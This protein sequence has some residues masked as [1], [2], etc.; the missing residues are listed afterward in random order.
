MTRNSIIIIAALVGGT[1]GS[2]A[3]AGPD[4]HAKMTGPNGSDMGRVEI[5]QGPR[6][7]LFR[8]EA[9]GLAESWHG[10]HVH[11]TGSC[12]EGLDAADGHYAPD[13][14]AHGLLNEAG[15]HAGD[16]PNIYVDATG[17]AR[18]EL[19]SE[20]LSVDGDVAPLLDDDGS[21]IMIHAQADSYNADAGA[22]DRVSC[23]VVERAG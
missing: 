4:A 11:K 22:G 9:K 17:M 3:G 10:F 16:L 1:M 20:R 6:G 12:A 7:V 2:A 13:G 8:V 23:G 21:A 18:A 19:Y 5:T 15:H 14:N